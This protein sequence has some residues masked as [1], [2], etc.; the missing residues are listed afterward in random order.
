MSSF[1]ETDLI[2]QIVKRGALADSY[3]ESQVA[4][5][6]SQ[7]GGEDGDKEAFEKDQ[8]RQCQR[9]WTAMAKL[10]RSQTSKNRVIDTLYFGSF[11]KSTAI[12]P[13]AGSDDAWAFYAYCPGPRSM[14]TLI[15]NS[16]NLKSISQSVSLS[17]LSL[18]VTTLFCIGAR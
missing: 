13:E 6:G 16:Q 4:V 10:V 15:E 12:Q 8:V 1:T 9:V 3:K 18:C 5:A 17:F 2:K 14:F 11:G 7:W